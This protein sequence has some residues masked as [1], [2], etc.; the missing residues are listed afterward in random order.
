MKIDIPLAG[1]ILSVATFLLGTIVP[2]LYAKFSYDGFSVQ[3][4]SN[5]RSV[6]ADQ[7][8]ATFS[9]LLKVANVNQD[10]VLIEGL[11][12][13][14][15]SVPGFS[16]TP[17]RTEFKFFARGETIGL[18]PSNPIIVVLPDGGSTTDLPKSVVP[19]FEDLP[20][21]V[22]K[23]DEDKLLGI[24]IHFACPEAEKGREGEASSALYSY[25]VKNGLP[26]HMRINGKYRGFTLRILPI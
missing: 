10:A 12:A 6:S 5:I 9:T 14:A 1:Y 16:F 7:K 26:I 11:D 17:V 18:P 22:V 2:A 13:P 3:Q 20:P 8:R 19:V 23:S 15:V 4:N 21:L 24:T 25:V